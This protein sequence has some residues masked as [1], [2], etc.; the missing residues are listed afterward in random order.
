MKKNCS[1]LLL[2]VSLVLCAAGKDRERAPYLHHEETVPPVS[3]IVKPAKDTICFNTN[4]GTIMGSSPGDQTVRTFTYQ[5]QISMVSATTGFINIDGATNQLYTPSA[6]SQTTWFRR[7]VIE[8]GI[9]DTSEAVPIIV[10]PATVDVKI[11]HPAPVCAPETVNIT[12]ATITSGSEPGLSYSY[13][14]DADGIFPVANPSAIS[15]FTQLNTNYY[16]KASNQCTSTIVPVRV[17]IN[18]KPEL[19]AV[20]VSSPVCKGALVALHA[21]SP[22]NTT[23]WIGIG[24]GPTVEVTPMETTVYTAKATSPDGCSRTATTQVS[25]IDFKAS[26]TASPARIPAGTPFNLTPSANLPYEVNAWLPQQYFTTQT[27]IS[28][29]I[30][31]KDTARNFSVVAVSEQGCLDTAS[32][33]VNFEVNTNDM[34]IPNAFTP[35]RDGKNDIFKVYGSSVKEVVIQIFTQWGQLIYETR[36]NNSG[37]D[38]TYK[39]SPQPVGVYMYSIKIRLDNE[40]SF[41]RKGSV[42]LLR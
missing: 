18:E 37:W 7:I 12:A 8:D 11:T 27:A 39:G 41:I 42:H 17:V 38:G 24:A 36:D 25:V 2:L 3:N 1:L 28:Q 14:T 34:F 40:D 35:N 33:Q 15:S 20:G 16:I 6:L 26:L 19:A 5:W 31:V 9:A 21:Y 23:E 22:G 30:S 29:T 4:P 32:I 10:L 13:F